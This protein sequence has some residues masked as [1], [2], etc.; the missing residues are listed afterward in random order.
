MNLLVIRLKEF[1]FS[2]FTVLYNVNSSIETVIVYLT[3]DNQQT[4]IVTKIN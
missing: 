2:G 1:H 3:F 4:F